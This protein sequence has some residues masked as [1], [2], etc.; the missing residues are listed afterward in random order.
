MTN[1]IMIRIT[2]LRFA[3]Q[4]FNLN[5][6]WLSDTHFAICLNGESGEGKTNLLKRVY[7]K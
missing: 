6:E 5:K 7:D 4:L 2:F 3:N 1:Q